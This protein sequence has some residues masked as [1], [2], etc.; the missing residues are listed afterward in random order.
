MGASPFKST[1]TA[2]KRELI[3]EKIFKADGEYFEGQIG[4]TIGSKGAT[5]QIILM[6]E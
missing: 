5:M 6:F 2:S 3:G 4:F 1:E